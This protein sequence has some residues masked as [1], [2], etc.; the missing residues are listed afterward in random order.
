[1]HDV[2]VEVFLLVAQS[3]CVITSGRPFECDT[4][5]EFIEDLVQ[6]FFKRLP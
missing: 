3:I 6:F 4:T 2:I 1:M 5:E